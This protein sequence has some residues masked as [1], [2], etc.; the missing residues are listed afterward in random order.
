MQKSEKPKIAKKF[1][2]A[3]NQSALY[4]E[5]VDVCQELVEMHSSVMSHSNSLEGLLTSYMESTEHYKKAYI[6]CFEA[7]KSLS[8]VDKFKGR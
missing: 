4:W 8:T 5:L 1:R 6:K 2:T 3:T 7:N